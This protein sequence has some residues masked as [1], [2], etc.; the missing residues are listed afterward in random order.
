MDRAQRSADFIDHAHELGLLV[1]VD[2]SRIANAI[3]ALDV[4]PRDAIGDADIVT[5]GGTKNG[6]LFGD[7]VLVRRPEHFGGIHFVQ[8]QIGHLASKHRFVAAQFPAML[9]DGLWLRDGG[10]RQRHGPQTQ[11]RHGRH[12][13]C[14]WRRRRRPTRCSSTSTPT[15]ATK[16]S[17]SYAVHQ[18]DLGLPA[19]RFVCSWST[20]NDD[21]DGVLA[22]LR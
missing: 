15:C 21:V 12:W 18:P 16:L 13:G 6:M 5:V 22:A 3:A 2:G 4:S 19:V 11:R 9:E 17:R 8:K 20:T 14:R 1:H 10:T 7:A